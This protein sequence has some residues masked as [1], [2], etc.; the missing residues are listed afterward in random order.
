VLIEELPKILVVTPA[1]NEAENLS[2]LANS[3]QLQSQHRILAWVIVDDGSTDETSN[4][5]NTLDFEFN[6]IVIKRKKS[7][8]LITGAAFAAWWEGVEFGLNIYPNS[9]YVMKLDADVVLDKNYFENIFTELDEINT[10]IIGGMIS[11]IHRE[12]KSYVPGPVKMYSRNALDLIRQL[13]VATGFDVMDEIICREK[14]FKIQTIS[15]AK[16][17]MNRQ[18][19]HSQGLLHGRFRNGLVCKWVGYAP[20]YFILHAIRY[21]FRPPYILGTL[22][23]ICGYLFSHKGPYP[24][25]LRKIHKNIQRQRLLRIIRSPAKT[26]R[27]L[28]L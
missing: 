26:L 3:I 17:K 22:W 21:I 12:Q 25:R 27:D 28:Y 10:G 1:R 9:H 18:I 20:E 19:G 15:S 13:P 2:K 23:M 14:G 7:G 16:F 6:V 11:N 5:A 8:K 24:Q 4:V